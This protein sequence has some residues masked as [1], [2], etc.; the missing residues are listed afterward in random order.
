MKIKLHFW[1]R[2]FKSRRTIELIDDPLAFDDVIGLSEA[3]QIR[4]GDKEY[5][6]LYE[7]QH[8]RVDR[9]SS[10]LLDFM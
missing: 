7:T 1:K 2:P 6:P 9:Q 5:V 8:E 3:Q 10:I 4:G